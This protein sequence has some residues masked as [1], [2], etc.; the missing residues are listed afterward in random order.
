MKYKHIKSNFEPIIESFAKINRFDNN[1]SII[2]KEQ[3]D[4]SQ[5]LE[6][7]INLSQE[8]YTLMQNNLKETVEKFYND[9]LNNLKGAIN[10]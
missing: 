7:A 1:N 4:Y 2:Y 5:A 6:K 8:E 9:S 3:K 10:G